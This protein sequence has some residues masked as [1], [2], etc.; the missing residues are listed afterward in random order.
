[1]PA[2]KNLQKISLS[3][4]L[5]KASEESFW[6]TPQRISFS[7]TPRPREA[8]TV[9]FL[10]STVLRH[11]VKKKL[12]IPLIIKNS[13]EP[14]STMFCSNCVIYDPEALEIK[15]ILLP[16]PLTPPHV[17]QNTEP[18]STPPRRHPARLRPT[19]MRKH[20]WSAARL[21]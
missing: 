9:G 6:S 19:R 17:I 14:T 4:F 16:T 5:S 18:Q 3:E 12:G 10:L 20:R 7:P 11:C 13:E 2:T 21:A 1:M 8:S 15:I